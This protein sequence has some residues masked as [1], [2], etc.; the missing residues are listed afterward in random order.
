[1][2]LLPIICLW[3]SQVYRISKC[4]RPKRISLIK[5]A[6]WCPALV[7]QP[8]V[9]KSLLEVAKRALLEVPWSLKDQVEIRYT[10][11]GRQIIK[12][13]EWIRILAR[14]KRWTPEIYL[15]TLATMFCTAVLELL[16]PNR[17]LDQMVKRF[18]KLILLINM[19]EETA[20]YRT[21]MQSLVLR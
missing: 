21:L 14:L 20:L 16:Y 6:Q 11:G 5:G 9:R 3:S 12:M 10:L 13:L 15:Q 18:T 1:M 4:L 8:M 19:V 7:N 17:W 2:A